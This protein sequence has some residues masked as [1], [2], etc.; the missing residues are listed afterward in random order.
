MV[1]RDGEGRGV[2]EPPIKGGVQGCVHDG[3]GSVARRGM[4]RCGEARCDMA[5]CGAEWCGVAWDGV[6]WRGVSGEVKR[7]IKRWAEGEK[8]IEIDGG[9]G[10]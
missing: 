5:W 1:R 2:T 4:A 10:G 9:R 6:A 3:E 7:W 8:D